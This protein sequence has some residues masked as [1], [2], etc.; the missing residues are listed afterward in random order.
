MRMPLGHPGTIARKSDRE[1]TVA[2][3]VGKLKMCTP[4]CPFL[5]FLCGATVTSFAHSSPVLLPGR[6]EPAVPG[7]VMR[8]KASDCGW[9]LHHA[10]GQENLSYFIDNKRGAFSIH[11]TQR[12]V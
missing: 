12:R 1:A 8:K 5:P 4:V 10:K 9:T 6:S 2:Q 7:S 3:Q 11:Q